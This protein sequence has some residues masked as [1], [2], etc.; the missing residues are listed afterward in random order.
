MILQKTG[1][2]DVEDVD[3]ENP[4]MRLPRKNYKGGCRKT[5]PFPVLCVGQAKGC[6]V[7]ACSSETDRD[8]RKNPMRKKFGFSSTVFSLAFLG[9]IGFSAS[10]AVAVKEFKDAFQA[11]YIK[12]DSTASNDVA[13]ARA[14]EQANCGVCHAGGNN[15]RIRNDYGKELAKLVRKEEKGNKAK[16]EAALDAVAKLKSKPADPASPTFG[17]KIASGKLPVMASEAGVAADFGPP[18]RPRVD[19]PVGSRP[20]RPDG[21]PEGPGDQPGPRGGPDGP[22]PDADGPPNRP[23]SFGPGQPRGDQR[24]QRR[25]WPSMER[26]DPE[27]N[28]L[29]KA[30]NELNQRAEELARSYREAPKDQLGKLKEELKKLVSEQFDTRQQRRKLEL[31]RLEEELKRLRDNTDRRDKNKQQLVDKRVT[32]LLG[33][34][35]ETGF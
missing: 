13:L 23:G 26:N 4:K 3:H 24:G 19:G 32:D 35:V 1:V 22:P 11:K 9:L 16:I 30:E 28:K 20:P 33:N 29:I 25:D 15:K 18:G 31:T 17:E 14:F 34:E 5:T 6:L 27:M 8:Q 2:E 12:T 7:P 10:S 21:Q